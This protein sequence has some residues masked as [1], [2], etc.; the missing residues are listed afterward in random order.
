MKPIQLLLILLAVGIFIYILK[1]KLSS[2]QVTAD[3]K[4]EEPVE[5]IQAGN[6]IGK[7]K[8]KLLPF[9]TALEASREFIYNIA[10]AVMQKFS[11]AAKESLLT[12]GTRLLNAGVQY[13]HVVDVFKIS[14]DKQR[15]RTKETSKDK[16]KMRSQLK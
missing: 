10:K 4:N 7:V 5:N 11:P 2:S 8:F 6:I 16:D 9:K 15:L 13:I 3:K 12:L 14:L 1:A